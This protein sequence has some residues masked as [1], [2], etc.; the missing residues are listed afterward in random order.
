[1]A[2]PVPAINPQELLN[3]K[4]AIDYVGRSES[5]LK[6]LRKSEELDCYTCGEKGRGNF[7]RK[8]DLDALFV[9]EKKQPGI[10]RFD[11]ILDEPVAQEPTL[12]PGREVGPREPLS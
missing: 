10:G 11:V 8:S 2:K 3:T 7:Y 6:R 5:T 4:Q 12:T 9:P 1:M